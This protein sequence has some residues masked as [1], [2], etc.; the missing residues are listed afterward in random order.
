MSCLRA[1]SNATSEGYSSGTGW[2]Y[3]SRQLHNTTS[4]VSL[5]LS[6]CKFGVGLLGF[7]FC[8]CQTYNYR[9]SISIFLCLSPFMFEPYQFQ[10]SHFLTFTGLALISSLSQSLFQCQHSDLSSVV[11][12]NVFLGLTPSLQSCYYA[13]VYAYHLYTPRASSFELIPVIAKINSRYS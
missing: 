2:A 4:D 6:D 8:E 12:R 7:F 11:F 1:T 3:T 9:Y 5:L 10:V 13:G